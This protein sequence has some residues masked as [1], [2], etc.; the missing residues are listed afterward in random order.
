MKQI[1]EYQGAY[2]LAYYQ[3]GRVYSFYGA[4]SA[5]N[6][7][8]AST[9]QISEYSD[10][11]L[12]L[13]EEESGGA[14]EAL[15]ARCMASATWLRRYYAVV[16]EKIPSRHSPGIMVMFINRNADKTEYLLKKYAVSHPVHFDG[17]VL[18]PV[19]AHTSYGAEDLDEKASQNP[20]Q[21]TRVA[22]GQ[23]VGRLTRS[24]A[25]EAP[26]S[27]GSVGQLT[28]VRHAPEPEVGRLTWVNRKR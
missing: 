27:A 12:A 10:R 14:G 20:G 23:A 9:E 3:V 6:A 19:S 26:S 21:L 17:Q 4:S 24:S 25:S 11:L 7:A 22:E 16:V 2:P 15:P 28:Q 8:P 1:E 5:Q 18:M 13:E